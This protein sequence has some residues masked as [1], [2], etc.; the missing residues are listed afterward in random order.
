[1]EREPIDDLPGQQS[2]ACGDPDPD[3]PPAIFT[4][5]FNLFLI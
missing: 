5:P 2:H 4:N 3:I 1:M